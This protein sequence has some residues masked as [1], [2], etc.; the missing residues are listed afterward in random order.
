MQIL[1]DTSIWID[2][3]KKREQSLKLDDLLLD[4]RVVIND[5]ILA[6]LIPLLHLKKQ[7]TIIDLLKSVVSYPLNIDWNLIIKWQTMCLNSGLNGIGKPDL[8]ITQN[9]MQ[10]NLPVYSLDKHFRSLTNISGLQLFE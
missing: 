8:L 6:E 7:F 9:A 10:N 2:F 3:F 5:I 1:V 4:D